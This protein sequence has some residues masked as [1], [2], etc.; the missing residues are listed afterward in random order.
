MRP[1]GSEVHECCRQAC[2]RDSE[3]QGPGQGAPSTAPCLVFP[4]LFSGLCGPC[5]RRRLRPSRFPTRCC[6]SRRWHQSNTRS[7]TS[8]AW[9]EFWKVAYH[10][11]TQVTLPEKG[12]PGGWRTRKEKGEAPS[13]APATAVLRQTPAC[14]LSSGV[15]VPQH[16]LRAAPRPQPQPSAPDACVWAHS[17]AGPHP[18]RTWAAE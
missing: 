15:P 6:F 11:E 16:P 8:W 3:G 13:P 12:V 18:S 7:G 9:I 10:C 2:V 4:S 1:G 17:L 5:S 14:P